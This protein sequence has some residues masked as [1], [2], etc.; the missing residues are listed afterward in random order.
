VTYSQFCSLIVPLVAKVQLLSDNPWRRSQL[1]GSR[2]EHFRNDL[3][4]SLGYHKDEHNIACMLTD[5]VGNGSQVCAAHILPCSSKKQISDQLGLT[6]TDL[7]STRNGLFL[8]KN[9]EVAFDELKLSFVPKDILHPLSL[10]M[11]IWDQTAADIPIWHD[12]T[13][14]IGQYE[15]C[16]LQLGDHLP[17]RRAL[18]YQAYMAH[19]AS[20]LSGDSSTRPAEFGTPESS[21][22]KE[23]EK[24]ESN[25]ANAFREEIDI[26]DEEDDTL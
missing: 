13:D 7:N 20:S 8:A 19:T 10:K 15:G 6:L 17:Y 21:F 26:N 24:L 4:R 18:S 14:T 23:R 11:I 2:G 5:R 25:L 3:K 9:I 16:T 12:H 1:S 22:F